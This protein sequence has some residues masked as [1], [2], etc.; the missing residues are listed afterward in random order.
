MVELQLPKLITWVRFPSPAPLSPIP[1]S[2]V[3]RRRAPDP[4]QC[5]PAPWRR[6]VRVPWICH[7][8]VHASLTATATAR[9]HPCGQPRW[10]RTGNDRPHR[11]ARQQHSPRG[12][13]TRIRGTGYRRRG[14]R[15]GARARRQRARGRRLPLR[16]RGHDARALHRGAGLRAAAEHE[17]S[18]ARRRRAGRVR[19]ADRGTAGGSGDARG[20]GRGD[21]PAARGRP[22]GRA[23]LAHA[24]AWRG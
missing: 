21:Q 15:G 20:A 7:A 10:N 18:P 23:R 9:G 17:R 1:G 24:R 13:G 22:S 12:R 16:D 14:A 4:A 2:R 19:G 8:P 5:A 11:D 6:A 3:P